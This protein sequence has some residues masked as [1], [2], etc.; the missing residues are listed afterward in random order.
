MDPQKVTPS[1]ELTFRIKCFNYSLSNAAIGGTVLRSRFAPSRAWNVLSLCRHWHLAI[2]SG[3][4]GRNVTAAL[5]LVPVRLPSPGYRLFSVSELVFATVGT[6]LLMK[7]VNALWM[8][9]RSRSR[10]FS[11]SVLAI[12]YPWRNVS[13]DKLLPRRRRR[14][15]KTIGRVGQD[16][17]LDV[18]LAYFRKLQGKPAHHWVGNWGGTRLCS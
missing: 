6:C 18:A 4:T 5:K 3:S 7:P 11:L 10:S 12:E 15:I 17:K 8:F 9:K 16:R 2:R 1:V 13:T 14:S